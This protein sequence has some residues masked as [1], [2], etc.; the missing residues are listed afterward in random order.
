MDADAVTHISLDHFP[1]DER[2]LA[3]MMRFF[4]DQSCLAYLFPHDTGLTCEMIAA[5]LNKDEPKTAS[6][7]PASW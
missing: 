7:F 1:I 3:K 5:D 2:N 6:F 4:L